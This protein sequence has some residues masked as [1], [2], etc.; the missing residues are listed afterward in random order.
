MEEQ[1]PSPTSSSIEDQIRVLDEL[2]STSNITAASSYYPPLITGTAGTG[3][4]IT[5]SSGTSNYF[6]VY[7]PGFHR[8]AVPIW[9][10]ISP[11]YPSEWTEQQWAIEQAKE[12][13][14]I[15]SLITLVK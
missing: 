4:T 5:T 3:V 14:S 12:S 7:G 9:E 10:P 11:L 1:I 2:M 13:Y 15:F 8:T 6:T